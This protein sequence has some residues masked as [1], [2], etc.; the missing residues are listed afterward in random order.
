MGGNGNA[1][2]VAPANPARPEGDARITLQN[3]SDQTLML[4]RVGI[5]LR[6]WRLQ[7]VDDKP[8]IPHGGYVDSHGLLL[9]C[10]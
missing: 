5:L 8:L 6:G 3:R 2:S 1:G 7:I 9:T 10:G 4:S